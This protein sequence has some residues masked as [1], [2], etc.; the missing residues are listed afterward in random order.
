[1]QM[2]KKI[3]ALIIVS[4]LSI[5]CLV[6]CNKDE[7]N[8]GNSINENKNLT[9][10]EVETTKQE[11][12]DEYSKL[13]EMLYDANMSLDNG[14]YV[15]PKD[16][17]YTKDD[18]E[19]KVYAYI[20]NKEFKTGTINYV[21]HDLVVLH[22]KNVYEYFFFE[23][24]IVKNDK[25]E[26]KELTPVDYGLYMAGENGIII[27]PT[28]TFY[29]YQ[30]AF[31]FGYFS[32]IYP[33]DDKVAKYIEIFAIPLNEEENVYFMAVVRSNYSFGTPIE[34]FE[35]VFNGVEITY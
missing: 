31:E 17:D 11:L 13:N 3:L 18:A 27:N 12:K 6:G 35:K 5:S 24:L 9:V 32:Y 15:V 1:M 14:A 4:C 8:N 34:E 10:E 21:N 25:G 7:N 22:G 30:D 16:F 33:D 26:E 28:L 2:S 29:Q 19:M 23:N 20:K